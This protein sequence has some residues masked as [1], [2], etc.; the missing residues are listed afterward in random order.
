M[1]CVFA[2]CAPLLAQAQ[3]VTWYF[4]ATVVD[5][6]PSVFPGIDNGYVL[7]GSYVVEQAT[8]DE[9]E[10]PSYGEY[11]NAITSFAMQVQYM[12][13]AMEIYGDRETHP[14]FIN[15]TNE[16]SPG[17]DSYQIGL[18]ITGSSSPMYP[19]YFR[20]NLVD[21]TA[22]SFSTD[23]LPNTTFPL[24]AFSTYPYRVVIEDFSGVPR[25]VANLTS[26][27]TTPPVVAPPVVKP[28]K[29]RRR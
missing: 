25:I 21:V 19:I 16:P 20:I 11:Q 28:P 5:H 10:S 3:P 4:S 26:L 18:P 6:H 27:S 22:S 12:P 24:D 13:V 15:V 2:V 14:V 7:R 17:F 8:E 1:A 9:N 29:K 23:A